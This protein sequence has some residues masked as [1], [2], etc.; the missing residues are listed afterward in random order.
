V[1]EEQLPQGA[2]VEDN[3][4]VAT[5]P[6]ITEGPP[7]GQEG[8]GINMPP[9]PAETGKEEFQ[10]GNQAQEI[11]PSWSD[12]M[13]QRALNAL[14]NS[15]T[16]EIAQIHEEHQKER[17]D[18]LL[19]VAKISP[20]EAN[21]RFPGMP[22]PFKENID[23]AVAELQYNRFKTQQLNQQWANENGKAPW[24]DFGMGL[25]VGVVDP[26]NVAVGL[27]TGGILG[28]LGLAEGAGSSLMRQIGVVAAHNAAF[29]GATGAAQYA[30]ESHEHLN[31]DWKEALE[32]GAM[33]AAGMTALHITVAR[34]L[35]AL[36]TVDAQI[37]Q[38]IKEEMVKTAAA[39]HE[40]G[41]PVNV[42]P[43]TAEAQARAKG[44]MEG[45]QSPYRFAPLQ[46]P[47]DRPH[48]VAIN[49]EGNP[50]PMAPLEH[51]IHAVD[52]PI[53]A[54]NM[55]GEGGKVAELNFSRDD[56]FIK[57]EEPL[58]EPLQKAAAEELE[59]TGASEH[60]PPEELAKMPAGD[61]LHAMEEAPSKENPSGLPPEFVEALKKEGI[62]G[63]SYV[64]RNENGAPVHS[65]VSLFDPVKPDSVTE[66]NPEIARAVPAEQKAAFL[67][68]TLKE[69]DPENQPFAK[70]YHDNKNQP[71]LN[72]TPDYMDE[73]VQQ[74]H[75]EALA[76]I[77]KHAET[78]PAAKALLEDVKADDAT[79]AQKL[80]AAQE[81]ADCVESSLT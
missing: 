63:M 79:D 19:G 61:V 5:A 8:P 23:P 52:D 50:H 70:E 43:Q 54:N 65:G 6:N 13:A 33:N 74:M 48:Y 25:A 78:N 31:P 57:A 68:R 14:E 15:P 39:E 41:A 64:G 42:A 4:T 62:K 7:T 81:L 45:E 53:A 69:G 24:T 9:V 3:P 18:Q 12:E 56:K 11:K 27:M 20:E 51:G 73:H 35:K 30:F 67:E 17:E 16:N 71:P 40:G 28:G 29:V 32:Y 58:P 21:K 72:S 36:R 46:H 66:A 37:P 2:P 80:N 1:N 77:E 60:I 47:S 10:S 55:A 38:D 22:E 49:T 76:K 44:E 34:G 75:D 26:V 59:R